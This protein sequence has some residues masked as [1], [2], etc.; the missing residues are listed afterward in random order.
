MSI[1][2]KYN[3]PPEAV[4][5]MI[6]DGHLSCLT[7]RDEEICAM[8]TQLISKGVGKMEAYIQISEA[9]SV[10]ERTVIRIIKRYS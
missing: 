3:I 8:Y 2:N 1:S 5:R 9:K 6:K 10:C 7:P 4:N